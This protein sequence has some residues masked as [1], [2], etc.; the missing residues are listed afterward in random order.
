MS[1]APGCPTRLVRLGEIISETSSER[2]F[3]DASAGHVACTLAGPEAVRFRSYSRMDAPD[4]QPK[5]RKRF[6]APLEYEA[7]AVR[8][9]GVKDAVFFGS[10]GLFAA[11]GAV[12]AE[13]VAHWRPQAPGGLEEVIADHETR[14]GRKLIG[15]DAPAERLEGGYLLAASLYSRNYYHWTLELLAGAALLARHGLLKGLKVLVDRRTPLVEASLGAFGIDPSDIVILPADRAVS[16]EQLVFTSCFLSETPRTHPAVAAAVGRGK[17][18]WPAAREG[19][20]RIFASRGSSTLR[21]LVNRAELD[22]AFSAEGFEV[23]DPGALSFEDQ[24]RLFDEAAVVVG[25]H[26]ANLTNLVYCRPDTLALEL[27][28][29]TEMGWGALCFLALAETMGMM[30]RSLIGQA[31]ERDAWTVDVAAVLDWATDAQRRRTEHLGRMKAWRAGAPAE[32][33]SLALRRAP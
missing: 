33:Q 24:V 12:V 26:G 30:H 27:F 2:F 22:A 23:V 3:E 18:A 11:D 21:P 19:G 13:S 14:M 28:H 31:L 29:P 17:E 6:L 9:Y 15:M 4:F 10:P 25:E 5:S 1:I 8:L 20:R 16:V 32:D 7:Q